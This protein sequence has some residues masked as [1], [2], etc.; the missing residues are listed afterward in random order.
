MAVVRLAPVF[1]EHV[2]MRLEERDQF[3]V[4]RDGFAAEDASR[5]L[6]DHS[7]RRVATAW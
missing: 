3:L 1:H 2:G 5:R 6:I 7:A 4:G